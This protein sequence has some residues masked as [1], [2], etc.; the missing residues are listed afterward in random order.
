MLTSIAYILLLGLFLG[1]ASKKL[2][3]P[4]LIGMLLT[5]VILGSSGLNLL[6]DSLLAISADLRKI[7]LVII[8]IRA[9]LALNI[10]DLKKV[11]LSAL[12]MSFMPACL[13]IIGVVIIAPL[14]FDVSIIEAALLGSVLA[15]VSPAV[16]VPKMLY[17]IENN[18]GTKKSIPQMIMAGASVDDIF[19]IVLFSAFS[20]L[21]EGGAVHAGSF[22]QIPVSII[23]GVCVGVIFGYMLT[24]YFKN[25]HMRD[26]IKLLLMLAVSFVLLAIEDATKGSFSFSSLLAIMTMSITILNKYSIL[27]KRISPKFSKLW[28]PAEV[29]LFVLVGATLDLG[30]AMSAGFNSIILIFSVLVFR[31]LGVFISVLRAKITAK[32]RLFCM[33]AY[34]P[35]ATV[36]AAIGAIPLSMGLQCGNIILTVAIVSIIITA[37]LGAFLI[38]KGYKLI[39]RD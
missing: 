5:G 13:E 37:P 3:L 16:I 19:V 8:L 24:I 38:E 15:A 21:A 2:G 34:I 20:T 31:M 29:L 26:S 11:G 39:D 14:L 10:K 12:L 18:I 30:F 4:P 36:Q 9:G 6:S 1:Y 17:M 25:F 27:A 35:K 22:I 33:L 23:S 7:A 32:E 28:I